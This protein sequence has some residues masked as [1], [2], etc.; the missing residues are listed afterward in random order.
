MK[1]VSRLLGTFCLLL[2]TLSCIPK[3][4]VAGG[5]Q[6]EIIVFA[7]DETYEMVG[8]ELSSILERE[9]FTPTREKIF[10]LIPK[11][12]SKFTMYNRRRN[13]LVVGVID[14]PL[15]D[16]ILAPSAR[17]KAGA[18]K[19]FVFGDED[20]FA[21]GQSVCIVTARDMDELKKVLGEKSD[22]I[23]S[24]FYQSV[25]NRVKDVL[26]KD[27][28]QEEIADRLLLSYNFTFNIPPGW[29]VEE[30]GGKRLIKILRHYPDRFITVCWEYSP[31][32]LLTYKEACDLRDSI[33]SVL[34]DGDM[35]NRQRSRMFNVDFHNMNAQK[36]DGIWKNDELVMG[37]PFRTYIFST[38]SAFYFIDVYVFTPGEKKWLA[39]EQL[40]T[41]ISTWREG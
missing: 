2:F 41:I 8:D 3:L 18:G 9:I 29:M 14:N 5:D 22:A 33:C 16:S 30:H 37:G 28:Y 40:E 15:I 38:E 12:P 27:G 10:T 21:K 26:Y 11:S 4:D 20:I 23:F 7:D 17:R 25:K 39:I 32:V 36:L 1:L 34:H 35:V 24:Y 31:R 13:V 19:N 6:T